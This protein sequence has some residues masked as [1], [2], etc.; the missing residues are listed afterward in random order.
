M[1][2]VDAIRQEIVTVKLYPEDQEH[3]KTL[4]QEIT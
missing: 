2:D 4:I 3:H 1:E